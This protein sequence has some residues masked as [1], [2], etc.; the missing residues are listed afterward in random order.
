MIFS[1]KNPLSLSDNKND[2]REMFSPPCIVIGRAST[3]REFLVTHFFPR[4]NIAS[5]FPH[6]THPTLRLKSYFFTA[7]LF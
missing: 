3:Y 6:T 5:F 2:Y 1:L 4:N 7:N